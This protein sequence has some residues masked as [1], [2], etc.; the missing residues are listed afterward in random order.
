MK[1]ADAAQVLPSSTPTHQFLPWFSPSF[2]FLFLFV[3]KRDVGIAGLSVPL[4]PKVITPPPHPSLDFWGMRERRF[5]FHPVLFSL[6]RL[7]RGGGGE[8]GF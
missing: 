5:C 4:A 3:I 2:L 7:R 1:S 6:S 8:G